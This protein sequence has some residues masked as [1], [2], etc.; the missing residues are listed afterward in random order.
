MKEYKLYFK[1]LLIGLIK[2]I[3]GDFP[4]VYGKFVKSQNVLPENILNYINYSIKADEIWEKSEE[5]WEAFMLVNEINFIDLI[6]SE[7]WYLVD[8]NGLREKIVI[9]NF[10][11]DGVVLKWDFRK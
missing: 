4:N 10:C 3:D 5:E 11:K 2:L 7:D 1:E 6:E 8:E 9:P